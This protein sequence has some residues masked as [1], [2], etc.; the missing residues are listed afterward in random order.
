MPPA[1][2]L[3][4]PP[5]LPPLGC[6][7][8]EKWAWAYGEYQQHRPREFGRCRYQLCAERWP[9]FGHKIA[10]RGLIDACTL[11]QRLQPLPGPPRLVA[12]GTCR[13]CGTKIGLHSW[14]GWLHLD[15]GFILC[16][17]PTEDAEPLCRAERERVDDQDPPQDIFA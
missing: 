15:A 6:I 17:E 9:C 4:D 7:H 10:L 12:F 13:W 2:D 1:F 3:N 11:E 5:K 8:L 16:M 14:W